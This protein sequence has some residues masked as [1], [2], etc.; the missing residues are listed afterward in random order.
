MS[1]CISWHLEPAGGSAPEGV[2][3][4]VDDVRSHDRAVVETATIKTLQSFLTTR[5]RVKLDVNV[6]FCVWVD[7]D[8]DDL[9]VLLITLGP[10]FGFEVLDPAVTVGFLLPGSALAYLRCG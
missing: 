3:D 9:A 8:V 6:A 5:D 10:D 7:G 2:V 4:L 1:S